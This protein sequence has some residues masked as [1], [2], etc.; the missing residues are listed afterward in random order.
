MDPITIDAGFRMM[1]VDRFDVRSLQ[2]AKDL[3][4]LLAEQDL[5]VRDPELVRRRVL[6]LLQGVGRHR[7]HGMGIYE[8]R[9]SCHLLS[10]DC[11]YCSVWLTDRAYFWRASLQARGNGLTTNI[12]YPKLFI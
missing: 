6:Q 8:S 4:V 9:H 1:L 12:G 3:V 11:R 7:L 2:H 10:T 5:V